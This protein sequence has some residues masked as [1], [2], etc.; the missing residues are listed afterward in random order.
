M[1]DHIDFN[2][3]ED[4]SSRRGY[5]SFSAVFDSDQ[6]G[7]VIKRTRM[8]ERDE[9]DAFNRFDATLLFYLWCMDQEDQGKWKRWMPRIHYMHIDIQKGYVYT[10]CE[11]LDSQP[12][13]RIYITC[14]LEDAAKEVKSE[15]NHYHKQDFAEVG[16]G[17]K[18]A[19]EIGEMIT[20]FRNLTRD[21]VK[22]ESLYFDAHDDNW[23]LRGEQL[24]LNDPFTTR[25]M[26]QADAEMFDLMLSMASKTNNV[27]VVK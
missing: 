3:I 12:N 9:F 17:S 8:P 7:M 23:M 4:T 2:S 22:G 20:Y 5:G 18:E 21:P 26:A 10:I 15:V 25:K 27:R 16:I 24:V 14:Y 6:A 1:F 13:H 19:D 11:E